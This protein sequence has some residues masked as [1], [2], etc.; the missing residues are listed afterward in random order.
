MS[1][2]A[3]SSHWFVHTKSSHRW[4]PPQCGRQLIGLPPHVRPHKIFTLAC[5]H[6][7]LKQV[8]AITMWSTTNRITPHVRPHEIFTLVCPH[9]IFT[10]VA[11]IT[12]LST[13]DRITSPC[14][15]NQKKNH[16]GSSTQKPHTGCIHHN[17]VPLQDSNPSK[18]TRN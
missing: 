11:S 17:V 6:R 7:N 13:T 4:P 14:P 3:K 8:A 1:V 15:S 16:T 18:D 9:K 5:P 2:H 10:Q 12:M